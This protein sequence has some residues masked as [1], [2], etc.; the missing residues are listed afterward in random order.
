MTLSAKL[1]AMT[2]ALII[3]TYAERRLGWS[4]FRAAFRCLKKT[5]TDA[6]AN[7]GHQSRHGKLIA[8]VPAQFLSYNRY[9]TP[10]GVLS[11]YQ[12]EG[13]EAV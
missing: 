3:L 2:G 7:C 13:Q 5:W 9:K 4:R 10:D 6:N 8:Q 11:R 1:H 12:N